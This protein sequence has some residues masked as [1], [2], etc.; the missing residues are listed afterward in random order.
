MS[1]AN[2]IVY[3]RFVLPPSVASVIDLS[4]L[5]T[6]VERVD[7]ELTAAKV[8]AKVGVTEAAQPVISQQFSDFLGHN[9]LVLKN[10]QERTTLIQ[11][12]RIL[13]EKAPVIHMTFAITVDRKS[14]EELA[15]WLRAEINPQVVIEVGLQPGLVAGVYV[16]T[17]NH[18]HDLSLRT[19]L[20]DGRS[21]LAKELG[22]LYGSDEQ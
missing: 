16:R 5:I 11:Q 20:K 8:H 14:L 19:A 3:T 13:K 18:V 10:S 6:E 4:R 12:L 15:E 22:V 17:S 7:N 1:E 9:N 2:D 21:V